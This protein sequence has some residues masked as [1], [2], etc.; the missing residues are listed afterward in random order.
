MQVQILSGIY[1]DSNSDFRTAYPRNLIPVP[2]GQGIS[3]GYLR[4]SDGIVEFTQTSGLDRG[5][6]EWDG[7]CYR[8]C[9]TELISVSSDGIITSHGFIAGS[10][11]V[12]MSYSFDYLSIVGGGNFYLFDGSTLTQVTDP[13][14]GTV[15]DH[16]WIDGY[17]FLTDG[18]N[19]IVTEL[20]NPFS[21]D[22]LKYGSSEVNPDNVK[23]TLKIRNE[24]YAVNRY[25]IESFDNV[26]GTGFPFE[27][28]DGAQIER[29]AIGT[30]ACCVFNDA[31]A[32]VGGKENE[33]V[34]VW[35]GINGSAQK[36]S[37]RE[38]ETELQLYSDSQLEK[39]VLESRVDKSHSWLYMHLPGSTWVYDLNATQEL[40][41][42]VWFELS[43]GV[44]KNKYSAVN[45]VWC[46]NKWI[47]GDPNQSR[48]GTITNSRSDHWGS[49][50]DWEF[51]TPIIYNEGRGA[52]IHELELVSLTGRAALGKSP[53][54]GTSYSTD[55]IVW[56]NPRYR[57]SGKIGQRNKRIVWLGQGS[58]ENWRVQKFFGTSDSF[59]SFARLEARLE[60]LE[61]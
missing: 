7:V 51:S 21:I 4:P 41:I 30:D 47:V 28:I 37:T 48:L 10:N 3:G 36:I 43:S 45:F 33:P 31:I 50:I 18:E 20:T 29:G 35:L 14:L 54:I 19:L 15:I 46:Y 2:K 25:S 22:P 39:I 38:I 11:R 13:D 27:R 55:G 8:V 1:T 56:S 5:G 12:S 17:F 58:L 9:G 57:T 26:G 24:A 49:L 44:G 23:A 6:I 16:V 52:Q 42:P 32:F 34:S 59:M 53:T 40:Q 61:N 60:P